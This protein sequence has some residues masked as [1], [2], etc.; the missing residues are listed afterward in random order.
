MVDTPLERCS[1]RLTSSSNRPETHS[2]AHP[3]IHLCS[4]NIT[5]TSTGHNLRNPSSRPQN[6]YCPQNPP[7]MPPQNRGSP[8]NSFLFLSLTTNTQEKS[9]NG[10]IR[11][12]P[13]AVFNLLKCCGWQ[14]VSPVLYQ[15]HEME[16][17]I[18]PF[19]TFESFFIG[20]LA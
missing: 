3:N 18:P 14:L 6:Q 17:S 5:S 13:K 10:R 9:S 15:T 11:E 1:P 12:G 19:S 4:K 2:L 16:S 7:H 8:S 20:S